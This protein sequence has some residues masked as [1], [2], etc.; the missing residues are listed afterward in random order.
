MPFKNTQIPDLNAFIP[1]DDY[2]YT[3]DRLVHITS[4][5]EELVVRHGTSHGAE[6]YFVDGAMAP[7]GNWPAGHGL[8]TDDGW[9]NVVVTI[10][11]HGRIELSVNDVMCLWSFY[12]VESIIQT[13]DFVGRSRI[14]LADIS[15]RVGLIGPGGR[16]S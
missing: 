3:R 5:R 7:F 11:E 12:P 9:N 15:T 16:R 2:D 10:D 6:Y 4:Q 1:A 13:R 14:Q 8:E